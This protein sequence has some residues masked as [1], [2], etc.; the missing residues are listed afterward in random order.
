MQKQNFWLEERF[1]N[2]ILKIHDTTHV[3]KKS[4]PYIQLVKNK[5]TKLNFFVYG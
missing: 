1:E 4:G 2:G 5:T 3:M